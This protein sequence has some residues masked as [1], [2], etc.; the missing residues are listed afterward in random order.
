ML[1]SLRA[2]SVKDMDISFGENLGDGLVIAT[3]PRYRPEILSN[4]R[5][6]SEVT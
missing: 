4:S 3:R 2:G 6:T 1:R 5:A